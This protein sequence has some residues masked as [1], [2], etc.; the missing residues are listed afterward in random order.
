MVGAIVQHLY[1]LFTFRHNG[2]GLPSRG[3]VPLALLS[4]AA[5][6]SSIRNVIE[7][8]NAGLGVALGVAG[9][10][11]VLLAC[12]SRPFLIAPIALA[13]IGGDSLATL[14]TLAELALLAQ[15]A[16][17]WQVTAIVV[18]VMKHGQ[19]RGFGG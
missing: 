16:T 14:A 19:Q 7:L 11:I 10:G 17:L 6:L 1:F 4:G 15:A 5:V 13:C 3:P 9:V 2:Q 18:F 12:R 8:S